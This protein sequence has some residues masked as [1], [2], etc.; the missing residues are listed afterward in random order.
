MADGTALSNRGAR[1]LD[2][3]RVAAVRE[4]L[5]PTA[6]FAED[7][8]RALDDLTERL[9]D[10]IHGGDLAPC[11][12]ALASM[13]RHLAALAPAA[14]AP[15]GWFDSRA[16]RLKRFRRAFD[17]A[18]SDAVR[19]HA[20]LDRRHGDASSRNG[21]LIAL[22]NEMRD[23]V[24]VLDAHV[25]AGRDWLAER[26]ADDRLAGF[27]RRL[28]QLDASLLAAVRRLPLALAAQNAD[29]AAREHLRATTDALSAWRTDWT[30]A[31]GMEAR[32]WRK[33]APAQSV[34]AERRDPLIDLIA[35]AD[36][37]LASACARRAEI[38]AR[39]QR[40]G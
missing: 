26:A 27:G 40:L 39:L 9:R 37:S 10:L 4:T 36:H 11:R 13:R 30:R 29:L 28:D 21:A 35:A 5:D 3:A 31:L 25:A 15:H 7:A 20:D 33:V 32:K 12:D 22:W 23:A 2:P 34:L 19:I 8:R 24:A 6:D 18:R 16:R 1:P 38:A 14:L 17:A